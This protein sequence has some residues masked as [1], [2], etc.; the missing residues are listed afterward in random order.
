MF[1]VQVI[2]ESTS[3]SDNFDIEINKS[4]SFETKKEANSKIKELIKS[5]DMK[6]IWHTF[7]NNINQEIYTNF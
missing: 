6:K 4:F 3:Y 5:F 1:L 7:I 2:K